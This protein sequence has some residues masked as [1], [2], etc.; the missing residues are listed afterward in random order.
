MCEDDYN[1]F[2][3]EK[4]SFDPEWTSQSEQA[5]SPSIRRA[6]QYQS[7]KSLDT[8]MYVGGHATYGTGGYV[9]ELRGRLADIRSNVS[10]LRQLS[11]I[12]D[13]TRAVFIHMSLYNPNVQLFT[14][15]TLL[16]ELAPTGG[17]YPHYY[18]EPTSFLRK[19]SVLL[20]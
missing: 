11:W 12:D 15:V 13:R 10:T 2:N 8:Y 9:Y 16:V 3:E 18:F 7:D 5:Y 1:V 17:A 6:F 20:R 19:Q 4:G 14:A